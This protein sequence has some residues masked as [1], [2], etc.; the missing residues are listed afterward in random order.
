VIEGTR[1]G[2][3]ETLRW[4]HEAFNQLEHLQDESLA[5]HPIQYQKHRQWLRTCLAVAGARQRLPVTSALSDRDVLPSGPSEDERNEL[6]EAVEAA[7]QELLKVLEY[8]ADGA[9]AGE[10]IG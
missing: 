1:A 8:D 4:L 7:R 2:N 5:P 9:H 3:R 6:V 10:L